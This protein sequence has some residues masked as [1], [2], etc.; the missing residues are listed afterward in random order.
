MAD[1]Q[2]PCWPCEVKKLEIQLK[3]VRAL[4]DEQTNVI[5]RLRA[6]FK[7]ETDIAVSISK[8]LDKK[9]VELRKARERTTYLVTN[10]PE[11]IPMP[12]PEAKV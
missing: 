8:S 10:W 12:T 6:A 2:G 5:R 3:R 4:M 7:R 9:M 11:G 1:T